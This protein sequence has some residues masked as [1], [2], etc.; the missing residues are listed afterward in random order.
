MERKH[1]IV[2][3]MSCIIVGMMF[4]SMDKPIVLKQEAMS[5]NVSSPREA[6][7]MADEPVPQEPLRLNVISNPSFEDWNSIDAVPTDWQVQT[8]A[9]QFGDRAYT[10]V[11]ANG[12]YAG[13]VAGQ[14]GPGASASSYITTGNIP[15]TTNDLLEPGLSLSFN[16]NALAVPD[17]QLGSEVYLNLI[18]NGLLGYRY[19]YY[20]L[21]TGTT[22]YT[23]DTRHVH[24]IGNDTINQ[25]NIF[26]RNITEDFIAAFGLG[27]LT[28]TDYVSSLYFYAASPAGATDMVRMVFDDVVLYNSTFTGFLSNG[29]F[30]TGTGSSWST[31]QSILGYVEQSPDSTVDSHSV[32]ITAPQVSLGS[33]WARCYR[34]LSPTAYYYALVPGMTTIQTDWKYNDTVGA[35]AGQ[36]AYLRLTFQNSSSYYV[37]YYFGIGD[38]TIH[39]ANDTTNYYVKI[40]G[41]GARDAWQTSEFDPYDAVS[42]LGFGNLPLTQ[43]SFYVYEAQPDSTVELLIDNFNILSSPANDPTFEF[44]NTPTFDPPFLGW[45]RLY[46]TPGEVTSTPDSHS[47]SSACNI[48]TVGQEDG[49]YRDSIYAEFDN[50]LATDFWWRLDHIDTT[51]LAGTYIQFKFFD[52]TQYYYIRYVLGKSTSFPVTNSTSIKHVLAENINQIGTWNNLARNITDDFESSF[53]TSADSWHISGIS[54]YAYTAPGLKLICLFDDIQFIDTEPPV[55]D[56]VVFDASPMYYEDV[57]VRVSTTDA[58]PGVSTVY[59]LYSTDSWSSADV[60][61]GVWDQGDW[62]NATIPAQ[63]YN[64][65]VEFFIQVTDGCG[66]E[67]IEDNGYLFYTYTVGDDV[68]PTLTITNPANNTDQSGLLNITADVDDPGSGIEW[69]RFN[70]DGSGAI[71]D[72]TAPYSQNWNLDDETLGSHF[73]IVTVRD[74][75]GHQVTKTHY[76]TVVDTID[77]V[78]D[79]PSDVEF[80]VGETGYNIDWNPTDIRPATYE[81]FVDSVSTYSGDWNATSEHIVISLDGLAV[82]TYNY[83]CVVYDEAGN[84]VSD[85]VLV[86]VNDVTPTTTPGTTTTEPTTTPGPTGENPL[87]LILA[88]AGI[89]VVGVLLVVLVVIRKMKK[90]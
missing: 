73:V 28:S 50:K 2:L 29:D 3:V 49:I 82:G 77:P 74:Y 15:P 84:S 22:L 45:S 88:V 38:D 44:E 57:L 90:E 89:G 14:G 23:N 76:F 42:Q 62:Y 21:R 58:R 17:L 66:V 16:W 30:E 37:H 51:G 55:V 53:S 34:Y 24:I 54:L 68:D 85:T 48:T 6:I 35:G 60:S 56:S 11:V 9:Y 12:T 39:L 63:V 81:V 70:A 41:F 67:K 83:T 47:G 5:D 61:P 40:P 4:Y 64:T 33:G 80:T 43:L 65:Q 78:L 32:N 46:Y 26:D 10:E 7:A 86:T 1:A 27:Q 75:A 31:Y 71:T 87:G 52:T 69:V 25:W 59:L 13:Y 72:Y 36:Y 20:H 79:S 8:S 18:T 19:F